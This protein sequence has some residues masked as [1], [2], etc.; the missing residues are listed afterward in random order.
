[1]RILSLMIFSLYLFAAG[2]QVSKNGLDA[3]LVN[4]A[5]T[6]AGNTQADEAFFGLHPETVLVEVRQKTTTGAVL[7]VRYIVTGDRALAGD[8]T[9]SCHDPYSPKCGNLLKICGL[10]GAQNGTPA[11]RSATLYQNS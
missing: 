7:C 9:Y 3:I 6:L 5:H 4:D 11:A 1:M 10:T 2:A 8:L